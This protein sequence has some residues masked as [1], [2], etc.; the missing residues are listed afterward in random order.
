M[1]SSTI[2]RRIVPACMLLAALALSTGMALPAAAQALAEE[3]FERTVPLPSGGVFSLSNV[4]GSVEIE[5]WNREEVHILARKF[6][7]GSAGDLRQVA[8]DVGLSPESVSV[9]TRYSEGSGV[10]VNVEFR[11]RVPARVRLAS[12]STVN[13][14]VTV[15]DVSGAGSLTAVNGNVVLARGAGIFSARATNGNVTLELLSLEGGL[16]PVPGSA[17]GA[18]P[19][20]ISAQTVNGNVAVALP[21]DAGAEL[22]ARTQ[23]GD[24]SSDLPLLAHSSA[25][26]RA[27]RGRVGSG[28]PPLLLRTVN[29]SIRLRIAQPLV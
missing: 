23:N 26:G 29:G 9:A 15:H 18:A 22:E 6:T 1:N 24:F 13:G 20:G 3:T 19:R 12:V 2:S 14:S 28:G 5:G 16:A 4:N 27:I 25:A 17:R 8:I 21:A 10:E 11:V 7:V